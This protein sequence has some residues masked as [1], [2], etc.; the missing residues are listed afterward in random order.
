MAGPWTSRRLILSLAV[1]LG[2]LEP[3]ALSRAGL[4]TTRLTDQSTGASVQGP[5][6]GLSDAN[7]T[8]GPVLTYSPRCAPLS[9][10]AAALLGLDRDQC[11]TLQVLVGTLAWDFLGFEDD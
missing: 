3:V 8:T 5:A 7:R 1:T 4:L 2:V 11:Q 10:A 9:P 6:R